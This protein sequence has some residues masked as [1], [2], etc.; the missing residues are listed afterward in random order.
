MCTGVS[1]LP[2]ERRHGFGRTDTPESRSFRV[3]SL[4]C[5]GMWPSLARRAQCPVVGG[6]RRQVSGVDVG[7]GVGC[8]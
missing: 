8:P 1:S 7:R 5:T 3:C 6:R 2:P 4:R